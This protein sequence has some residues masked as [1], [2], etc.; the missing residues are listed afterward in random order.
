MTT[1]LF[2]GGAEPFALDGAELWTSSTGDTQLAGWAR[3]DAP[4]PCGTLCLA[5]AEH[6]GRRWAVADVSVDVSCR[7]GGRRWVSVRWRDGHE[8]EPVEVEDGP[9]LPWLLR[10][11]TLRCLSVGEIV[12]QV[13]RYA[14]AVAGGHRDPVW[15]RRLELACNELA[16]RDPASG[17]TERGETG[18][19]RLLRDVR[20]AGGHLAA[21]AG[22]V[23]ARAADHTDDG[24]AAAGLAALGLATVPERLP[25]D[26]DAPVLVLLDTSPVRELL[27]ACEAAA[28]YE[29][30][31]LL[32]RSTG[33]A[34]P[35]RAAGTSV[36][37]AATALRLRLNGPDPAGQDGPERR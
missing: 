21:T 3:P 15:S 28:A 37:A 23:Q 11:R 18:P 16:R 17:R 5:V 10:A 34:S 30:A 19:V 22:T 31:W 8:L 20:A 13:A 27:R 9:E 35:A 2:V 6:E 1:L 32:A 4:A 26:A 7:D 25:E 12:D 14:V 24:T 33:A 29:R 36:D